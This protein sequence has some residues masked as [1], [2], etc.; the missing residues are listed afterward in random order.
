MEL[1]MRDL[2][3]EAAGSLAIVVALLHGALAEIRTVGVFAKARIEP[4][5]TR[6]LLRLVWQAST[7]DWICLGVLLIAAPRFGSSVAR[8]W[9][10]AAAVVV[11]TCA[12]L[13]NALAVRA[14]HPGWILMSCVVALAIAGS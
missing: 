6:R 3:L 12:A 11:Y 14:L 1:T 9:V 5:W 7:V 13:G 8:E 2:A 4:A 10:V